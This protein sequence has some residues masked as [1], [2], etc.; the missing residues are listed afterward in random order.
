EPEGS[1][2]ARLA[3]R[4]A[5]EPGLSA[6][7]LDG[8]RGEISLSAGVVARPG[9]GDAAARRLAHAA[10]LQI[11]EALLAADELAVEPP[12]STLL[13]GAAP[14]GGPWTVVEQAEAGRAY[15]AGAEARAGVVR[16]ALSRLASLSPAP[17][18]RS[19]PAAHGLDAE[20]AC[21]G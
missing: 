18:S 7:R 8:E 6:L 4:N 15:A 14:G 20:L 11:G 12:G 2:C 13:A 10:L 16:S 21:G 3:R 1:L 17:W 9:D 5:R 19:T